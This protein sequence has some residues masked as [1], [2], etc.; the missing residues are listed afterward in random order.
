MLMIVLGAHRERP[1]RWVGTLLRHHPTTRTWSMIEVMMIGV[2]VALIKIAE[3][4]TVVPG[5]AL[6]ALGGLV[7]LLP[8]IQANFDA[9]EVWDRVEWADD[10]AQRAATA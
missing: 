2:L 8:A 4:A 7:V 1:R 10:E 6:F 9:R 3:L 5:I